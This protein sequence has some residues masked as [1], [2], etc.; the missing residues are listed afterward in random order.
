MK[1]STATGVLNS[2]VNQTGKPINNPTARWVFLYFAGIHVLSIA[3]TSTIVLNLDCHHL[4]LLQAL[5]RHFV[6]LY[7]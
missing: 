4:A 3:S 2:N 7:V 6:D 1:V 5:G